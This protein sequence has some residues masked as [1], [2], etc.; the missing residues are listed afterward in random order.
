MSEAD[1]VREMEIRQVLFSAEDKDDLLALV[2]EIA[3]FMSSSGVSID[4]GIAA[5]MMLTHSHITT[6]PDEAVPDVV[7]QCVAVMTGN[8]TFE[9][10]LH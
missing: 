3:A 1:E 10:G 8:Y 9:G 7:A 5:M 2:K 6:L 4:D